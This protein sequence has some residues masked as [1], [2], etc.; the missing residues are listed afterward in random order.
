MY[1]KNKDSK[2]HVMTLEIKD[3]HCSKNQR[4]SSKALLI[5]DLSY[6]V[7]MFGS[8]HMLPASTVSSDAR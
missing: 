1:S 5:V 8:N 4:A 3:N 6:P 7:L 2:V